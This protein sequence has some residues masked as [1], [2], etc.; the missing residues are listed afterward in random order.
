[1]AYVK[2][3]LVGVAVALLTA[4]LWIVGSLEIPVY[5]TELSCRLRPDCY[6]GIGASYV[7]SGSTL[8]VA[9]AGF[10][11]GFSWTIRRRRSAASN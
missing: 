11:V 6:G 2:G 8:V 1:M 9:L 4:V 5:W 10:A 3:V 7:G